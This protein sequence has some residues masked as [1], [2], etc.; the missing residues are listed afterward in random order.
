MRR[1]R[2]PGDGR[3][4]SRCRLAA[5]CG[6]VPS[7]L[8]LSP[9]GLVPLEL[10]PLGLVPLGLVPRWLAVLAEAGPGYRRGRDCR[11]A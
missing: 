6:A 3:R 9:L 10:V 8:V 2:Q 1:Q 7:A 4:A 5:A 11:I